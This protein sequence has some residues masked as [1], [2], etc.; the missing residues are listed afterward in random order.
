MLLRMAKKAPAPT[1]RPSGDGN[2]R[3]A[4]NP[5]L[6]HLGLMHEAPVPVCTLP[7]CSSFVCG[8]PTFCA[9]GV[10]LSA[11]CMMF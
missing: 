11:V 8:Y 4:V 3:V 7:L 5:V 2:D 10:M 1:A 9:S 6:P